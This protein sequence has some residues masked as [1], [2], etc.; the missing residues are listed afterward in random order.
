MRKVFYRLPGVNLIDW[1]YDRLLALMGRRTS[2][3]S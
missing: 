2:A 1:S 3:S